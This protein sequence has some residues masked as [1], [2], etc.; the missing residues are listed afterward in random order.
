MSVFHPDEFERD[1]LLPE[2]EQA[3]EYYRPSDICF[4]CAKVLGDDHLVVVHGYEGSPFTDSGWDEVKGRYVDPE[5]WLH[6]DCAH[7]LA[8]RL[9]EDY[10]EVK[11]IRDRRKICKA[12]GLTDE[13]I[14][15]LEQED[16]R[17]S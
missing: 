15:K 6:V 12:I 7:D 3:I 13:E 9:L 4:K 2:D 11:H 5:I 8:L 1:A 17:V 16:G 14:A 10:L